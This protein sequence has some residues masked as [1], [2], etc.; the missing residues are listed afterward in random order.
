MTRHRAHPGRSQSPRRHYL[1]A[2]TLL[3]TLVGCRQDMHDQPKAEPLEASDFFADGQASRP[4]IAGTIARGWP[5]ELGPVESGLDPEGRL[6]TT[7]PVSLDAELVA[8]GRER[9][10]IFCSPCH[11]RTG[12]G[13]GMIVR[14]GF[15]RPESFHT[16][17][18]RE[19]PVGYF[20]DVITNGFGQMSSY[21]SQ[22]P[23]ADRWAIAAYIRALQLSRNTPVA[24]L[25]AGEI[26]RIEHPER[27]TG[28]E[29]G[30]SEE[31]T[32]H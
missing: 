27:F 26:E 22:V 6:V 7:L 14:R 17:R 8:R 24:V 11:A 5:V 31:E 15:K 20:F 16:Q 32:G 9:Y 4:P 28:N 25:S 12:E 29:D 1:L 2:I 23:V 30:A 19:I 21:R 18:L 13:N 3:L 10:D